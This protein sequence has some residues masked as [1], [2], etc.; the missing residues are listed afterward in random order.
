M[1]ESEY[2]LHLA[3]GDVVE[4]PMPSADDASGA[5]PAL[6]PEFVPVAHVAV[7]V[8]PGDYTALLA[9]LDAGAGAPGFAASC[10]AHQRTESGVAARS[11]TIEIGVLWMNSATAMSW[12]GR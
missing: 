3:L 5:S 6:P 1:C 7:V 9:E 8:D 4:V 10:S 11:T 12:P 2:A